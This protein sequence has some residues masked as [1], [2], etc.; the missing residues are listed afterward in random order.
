MLSLIL[1]G[2]IMAA[3]VKLWKKLD[4]LDLSSKEKED[5][6]YLIIALTAICLALLSF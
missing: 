4:T 2:F 3:V 1:A 5:T 6:R